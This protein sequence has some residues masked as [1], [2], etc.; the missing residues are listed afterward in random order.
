M[1]QL[2]Q[3]SSAALVAVDISA[4]LRQKLSRMPPQEP[5]RLGPHRAPAIDHRPEA[6]AIQGVTA[7][8]HRAVRPEGFVFNWRQPRGGAPW[9]R[10]WMG[11]PVQP[12]LPR[13]VPSSLFASPCPSFAVHRI[14]S[15]FSLWK[16]RRQLASKPTFG[17]ALANRKRSENHAHL[18]RHG[19][20]P[21]PLGG[22]PPWGAG[23]V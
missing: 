20:G 5:L 16:I 19:E 21:E 12:G 15:A 22:V 8:E 13:M 18:R 6:G 7:E 2:R 3:A 9:T 14:P 10:L 11:H 4:E 1:L 23:T 17:E